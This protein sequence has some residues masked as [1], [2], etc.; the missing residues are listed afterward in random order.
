MTLKI[1][2][3][4]P[5]KGEKYMY[6]KDFELVQE[7]T[8]QEISGTARLWKH[9][10]T[11]AE[12]LSINN[13][14]ENKCFGVAFRT[15]PADS[16][17]VA[18]ILEHSVLCGSKKFPVR[19]P[20]VELLK[21]SLQT[22]LN[23]FTFPDKTCY[24]VASTNIQDFYN[25]IEV[26]MDAVFHPRISQDIFLQEGWH[27]DAQSS[28]EPWTF[29]GVVYNE[30]KG[31]YST[32]D[33]I[34][35]EQSQQ[36]VFPDTLYSLD[37]GGEPETILRLSYEN[38]KNFHADYYHP[39]NARFFFWGDD[40]EAHRLH[41][42]GE[43]LS[44]Y[45]A[46]TLNSSI[47]LQEKKDMPRHIEVPYAATEDEN[48]ALFTVNWL[49][50]ETAD[51][52]T[53]M[54]LDM[55]S[56]ILEGLPGS[57][58]RKALIESG[59]GEDTTGIGLESDLRQM[60]YSV[61]LKGVL[62]QDVQ[63]A[64]LLIYDVL[65]QLV[66]EGIDAEAIEAAV[67]S[68]EFAL[69][70]NNSGRFPR[71]LAAMV[72]SLSTWLYDGDPLSPLAWEMPLAAI[73]TRIAKGERLF[74][75]AI[76]EWFLNNTHRSTVV[77]LPDM[78]LAA[79]REEQERTRLAQLQAACSAEERAAL[80]AETAH[81]RSIQE[82]ADSPEALATIPCLGL[83]DLPL[84][85]KILPIEKKGT[86]TQ[87]VLVHELDTSGVAYVSILFPLTTVPQHLIPLVPLLGRALTEMGSAKQDFVRMGMRIAAKTGGVG[88]A[89]CFYTHRNDRKT[90]AFLSVGGKAVRDKVPAL[91]DI[92]REILL[93]PNFNQEHRFS[94]ML[95][96]AKARLEHGLMAAG[97][98][99]VSL[100]LRAAY[101]PTGWLE[102]LTGGIS[103]LEAV[104]ALCHRAEHDWAS[105]LADLQKVYS[106][107]ISGT[108]CFA[109]CTADTA[110]AALVEPLAQSL[111][112]D[113]PQHDTVQQPALWSCPTIPTAQA[114]SIPAQI[115]FVG[116]GANLYDLG[117]TYHGSAQVICRYL[118]MGYLWEKV[119]VQGGAYG[120]MCFFDR[121]GGTFI[122]ASYRDPAVLNT[123]Q[124]YDGVT[125]YLR[126]F[127][128][129]ARTLSTAIVGAIGDVDT[130][131]LP[132]AKGMT[133]LA[134]YITG[135]TEEA[136][137][138]M[139]EQ[140]LSTTGQHFRDFAE[141]MAEVAKQGRICVLGGSATESAAGEQR[142]DIQKLL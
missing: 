134:R 86:A 77:L 131:M 91:F 8:L 54:L 23:A 116:K 71:G 48:R 127:T 92:L 11:G 62:P 46:K 142:W 85:N 31:V 50:C 21:G 64:E 96:E 118:R 81:L 97:H 15:P 40:D 104:R 109:D 20:F 25:L 78:H 75:N 105:V 58:L 1:W 52:T 36:S 98:S 10:K 5:Y 17:G 132:D 74:E 7:Q 19:E 35:A 124:A 125:D 30:M 67:N 6:Q 33:S 70:E 112:A 44:E 111:M 114:F 113:L 110:T 99:T 34:L 115:N 121:M 140:I 42:V 106:H 108:H 90:H 68:V 39:S 18:H 49:L 26:Y 100:R 24:P 63:Q 82:Q 120:A 133:S 72:Q 29:K 119:R 47:P 137:Q 55:L 3:E 53:A 138:E 59:L 95:L 12:V 102:E 28:D 129:D 123:L 76:T 56:H 139:R 2:Q 45:T 43:E 27:V 57:P 136:R 37:S 79:R 93:E 141:L 122:Q 41:I 51:S 4:T 80:V 69:R 135:D 38:F 126:T 83:D 9:K 107:I 117:Y 84:H 16:S 32:A 88:A 103:Y 89:P 87:P 128:P 101:T 73:K 130:Y 66:E 13:T 61:G 22:F 94:Q 14:D 65:A 60:Y